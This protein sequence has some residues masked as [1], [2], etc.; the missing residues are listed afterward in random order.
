M[1][2]WFSLRFVSSSASGVQDLQ[3]PR[4][5]VIGLTSPSSMQTQLSYGNR[6]QPLIADLVD[7]GFYGGVV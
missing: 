7:G 5:T 4:T 3:V 6:N 2:Q 1:I